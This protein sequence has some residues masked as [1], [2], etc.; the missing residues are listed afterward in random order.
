MPHNYYHATVVKCHSNR[1]VFVST[2]KMSEI[3]YSDTD[4]ALSQCVIKL[5]ILFSDADFIAT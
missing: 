4:F 5:F 2:S 3:L 1:P